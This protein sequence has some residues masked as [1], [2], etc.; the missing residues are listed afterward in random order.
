M[1]HTNNTKNNIP[2]YRA[3]IRNILQLTRMQHRI[4]YDIHIILILQ[5]MSALTEHSELVSKYYLLFV[6]NTINNLFSY[7]ISLS[8]SY[9]TWLL[10]VVYLS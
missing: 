5:A 2:T 3:L 8:E 6:Y 7:Y 4:F 9:L 1:L 10:L